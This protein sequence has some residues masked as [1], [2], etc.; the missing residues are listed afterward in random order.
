MDHLAY[1]QSL[2][3][4]Q[5]PWRFPYCRPCG[6]TYSSFREII[7]ISNRSRLCI[8]TTNSGIHGNNNEV[9]VQQK[10]MSHAHSTAAIVAADG[11]WTRADAVASNFS[12]VVQLSSVRCR[13]PVAVDILISYTGISYCIFRSP[14]VCKDRCKACVIVLD[15]NG[16]ASASSKP[17]LK[18][19]SS[20]SG[21]QLPASQ[22]N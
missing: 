22:C 15:E 17:M 13:G 11:R 19:R 18:Y 9:I 5:V 12:V 10:W 4:R 1:L 7:R 3:R 2:D 8:I 6:W 14:A 21:E 16:F 20:S